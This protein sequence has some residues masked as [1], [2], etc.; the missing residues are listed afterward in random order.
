MRNSTVLRAVVVF[1]LATMVVGCGILD[2]FPIPLTIDN[3]C[4]GSWVVVVDG[5]GNTLVDRLEYGHNP[6]TVDI[7]GITG[8]TVTL[9]AKGFDLKTRE[10][11]GTATE[12][13]YIPEHGTIENQLRPWVID[14]LQ[15]SGRTGGCYR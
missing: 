11:L 7:G 6:V 13:Y 14:Y 5:R 15:Y 1:G 2:L 12:T 3:N 4:P 8:G 9:T 10:P